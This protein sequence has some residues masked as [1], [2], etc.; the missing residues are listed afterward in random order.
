MLFRNDNDFNWIGNVNMKLN[1][2]RDIEQN[3]DWKII[4]IDSNTANSN[5][6]K[7][8]ISYGKVIN[9]ISIVSCDV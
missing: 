8:L 6:I 1:F 7:P 3:I 4:G 9:K 5:S 2:I